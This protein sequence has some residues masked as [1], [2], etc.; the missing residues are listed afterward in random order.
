METFV[1]IYQTPVVVKLTNRRFLKLN[2]SEKLAE[3]LT[4]QSVFG[5]MGKG[6]KQNMT[7]IGDVFNET[8]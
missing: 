6:D 2:G 8:I 4:I 5:I 1:L 7:P 3:V